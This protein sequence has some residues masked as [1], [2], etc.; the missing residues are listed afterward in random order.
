[1]YI[2]LQVVKKTHESG[3]AA[4]TRPIQRRLAL[5]RS[6]EGEKPFGRAPQGAKFLS[7]AR[8]RNALE[9]LAQGVNLKHSGGLFTTGE[10]LC[11]D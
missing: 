9:E 6:P 2:I 8:R 4:R 1:M 11:E 3:I 5:A 7:R 10:S